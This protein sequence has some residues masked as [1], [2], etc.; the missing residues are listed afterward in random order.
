MRQAMVE[1]STSQKLAKTTKWG[2]L[3]VCLLNIYQHATKWNQRSPNKSKSAILYTETLGTQGQAPQPPA[4]PLDGSSRQLERTA[5]GW[6]SQPASAGQ[7]GGR[8]GKSHFHSALLTGTPLAATESPC[9]VS[10][11][12]RRCTGSPEGNAVG[13]GSSGCTHGYAV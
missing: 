13:S 1:T 11:R 3:F 8:A 12:E 2:F 6:G 10:P 9:P 4:G 7:W 5:R